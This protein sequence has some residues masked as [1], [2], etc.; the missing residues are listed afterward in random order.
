MRYFKTTNASRPYRAGGLSFSFEQLDNIGGSWLGAL[1]LEESDASS[2]AAEKFPQVSEIT[3]E[4]YSALK[5]KPLNPSASSFVL[6]AP[7][8]RS[9]QVPAQVVPSAENS[10]A[11]PDSSVPIG[12]GLLPEPKSAVVEPPDELLQV[13]TV[14]AP[15]KAK[16]T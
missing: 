7:P 9:A 16:R 12:L 2:L 5:K 8:A 1:A 4:E 10:P 6:Q 11:S 15:A 13:E 3:E 14:K